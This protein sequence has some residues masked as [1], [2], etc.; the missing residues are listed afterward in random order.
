[1]FLGEGAF[2]RSTELQW[3][4][5]D[6]Y[7]GITP[8]SLI[9]E[10]CAQFATPKTIARK[11]IHKF[12]GFLESQATELIWK[13]RCSMTIARERETGITARQKKAKYTGPR[14]DWSDGYGYICGEGYCPCGAPLDEHIE[15]CPGAVLDPHAADQRLLQCLK[16]MRRL[17]T[18]EGMGKTPYF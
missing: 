12:V 13:P 3:S 15:Q 9:K 18:M 17:N 5:A 8:I 6:L 14:R 4:I 11:V 10:W 1:M 16:G 7:R 2:D